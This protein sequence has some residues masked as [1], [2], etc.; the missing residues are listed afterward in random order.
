MPISIALPVFHRGS[1]CLYRQEVT[2]SA[3]KQI[4]LLIVYHGRIFFIVF[5]IIRR[6]IFADIN[7]NFHPSGLGITER[8]R[9]F[10]I[11]HIHR[12]NCLVYDKLVGNAAQELHGEAGILIRAVIPKSAGTT[13]GKKT[14]CILFYDNIEC[15]S[16][17]TVHN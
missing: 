6:H 14:E 2:S 13:M 8:E 16:S 9:T 10:R 1:I 12:T 15:S 11:R 5:Q 7:S 4:K 17:R 3:E